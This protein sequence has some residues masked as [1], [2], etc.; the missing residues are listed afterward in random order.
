[1]RKSYCCNVLPKLLVN[2]KD[3]GSIGGDLNCT[4]DKIDATKNP[5]SKISRGLSRLI[6]LKNWQDSYR[7]LYPNSQTYSRY[8][9]NTR[10]EGA[11]RIDRSYHFGEVKVIEAKYLPIAFSDH[12]ALVIKIAVPENLS[13]AISPKARPSFKLTP[14]VI[15]D[16]V[17][18]ERLGRAMQSYNRVK[19]FQGSKHVGV[20]QWWEL[21]VKPGILRLGLDRSKEINKEKREALN[22]LLLRQMYLTK[23]MRDG[24][25]YKLS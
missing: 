5:E 20:L 22:L 14:E 9:E 25:T 17:F 13:R 10:G 4:T 6:K 2:C 8:Y 23:K 11:S 16:S 3:A 12:F 24:H 18:Q 21:L 19:D 1:M 7:T 15:K